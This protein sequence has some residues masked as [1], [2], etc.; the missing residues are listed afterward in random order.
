MLYVRKRRATAVLALALSLSMACATAT[1]TST[2]TA[3]SDIDVRVEQ[4]PDAGFNVQDKGATSIAYQMTVH[5][6][7]TVPI[8]LRKVEMRALDRSPYSLR[9]TPAEVNEVIEPGKESAV[10]F[11]MWS[12]HKAQRSTAKGTVWVSGTAY[13]ESAKGELR[14]DFSQSF[15]EP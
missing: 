9:N 11:T 4:L 14:K 13:F 2:A 10:P 5:N 8:T 3:G 6:R 1:T 12:Y 7:L 15:Q